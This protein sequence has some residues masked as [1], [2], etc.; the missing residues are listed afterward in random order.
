MENEEEYLRYPDWERRR[1]RIFIS[2]LM[3]RCAETGIA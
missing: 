1:Q 2:Q 3:Q